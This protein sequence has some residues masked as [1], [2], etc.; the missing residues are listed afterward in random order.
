ML[1][2]Y[3]AAL[4]VIGLLGSNLPWFGGGGGTERGQ[5]WGGLCGWVLG[6]ACVGE[7]GVKYLWDVRAVD[8]DCLHVSGLL[9]GLEDPFVHTCT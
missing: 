9:P 4:V 1:A 2:P 6:M 3:I 5:R 8:G 7:I